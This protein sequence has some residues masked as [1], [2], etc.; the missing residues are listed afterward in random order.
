MTTTFRNNSSG[1][2]TKIDEQNVILEQFEI[3]T[4]KGDDFESYEVRIDFDNK[5]FDYS[6][7]EKYLAA[8]SH[9]V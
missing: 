4:L 1:I 3:F 2:T 5:Q 8:T 9:K 6:E 7:V